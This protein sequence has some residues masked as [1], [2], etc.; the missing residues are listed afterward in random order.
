MS[1]TKRKDK[2]RVVLRSGEVQRTN[3][4]YQ[5]SWMDG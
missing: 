5:Y 1:A 2:S 4:S 3:G